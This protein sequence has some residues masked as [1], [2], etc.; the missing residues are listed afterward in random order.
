MS[1]VLEGALEVAAAKAK[2]NE[3]CKELLSCRQLLAR[4]LQGATEEFS[5][6][7]LDMIWQCIEGTPEIS[8]IPVVNVT[9]DSEKIIGSDTVDTKP[10]EGTITYDVRF[11]AYAPCGDTSIK[12]Y[13]NLEAQKNLDVGYPLV[14][15]GIYYGSRMISSQYG[16]EFKNSQYQKI[17]KV[18][19]IWICYD[20]PESMGNSIVKYAITK[21]DMIG[22]VPDKKWEYDKMTL[23]FIYLNEDGKEHE[24]EYKKE[25]CELIHLLNTVFS[26]QL[27]VG[28]KLEI[29]KKQHGFEFEEK[30]KE[31]LNEMC[32]FA[33]GLEERIEKRVT[34]RITQSVTE[35]VTKSVTES[36][37]KSVTES[38]TKSVTESVTK[39]VTEN[40][41]KS[42]TEE[43][44]KKAA[45]MMRKMNLAAEDMYQMI[46]EEYELNSSQVREIVQAD[47]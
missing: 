39:S 23:V 41:T 4:I 16:V 43:D 3:Y 12:L 13:M 40:V 14:T 33:E 37:T 24:E 1:N 11:S 28:Q 32:N 15:R 42:I 31:V 29:L 22:Y 26:E 2:Y 9:R 30:D 19:S 45:N 34:Q 5:D 17:K 10:N 21:E 27:S 47:C 35:S 18:Y 8:K 36:V 20:V 38:V 44:I 7:P 46:A 25:Y 6:V